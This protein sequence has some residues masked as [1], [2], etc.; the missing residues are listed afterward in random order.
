MVKIELEIK[1]DGLAP[2][3]D[4]GQFDSYRSQLALCHFIAPS[5]G[6]GLVS[7]D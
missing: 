6:R 2:P 1:E 7:Q 3:E 5:V 4:R